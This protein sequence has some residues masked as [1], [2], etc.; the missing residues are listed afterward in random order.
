MSLQPSFIDTQYQFANYIRDPDNNPAPDNIEQ[1]RMTIYQELFYN[2][3]EGFA[4]NGFPVLREITTDE[5]WHKMIRDFM[6]KHRCKTPLFHEISR[7][8][9][10]YL[11]NERDNKNDPKFMKELAHYEW[12]E[13]ALSV[14]DAD[15]KP[16]QLNEG[17]DS[18]SFNLTLSPLAWSLAY[19]YPVHHI[20]PDFKPDKPSD[21]PHYLLVYRN[22]E[23]S[24]TFLE[25]NPVSARLIELLNEGM[26]GQ[27]AA[28]QIAQEL[29][30][31]NP[32][33]VIEG[34]RGLITD[35]IQREILVYARDK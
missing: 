12:V 16:V 22:R 17:Q 2:N 1:R 25:L 4:A 27:T 33:V 31:P 6:V 30:H 24:V 19:H 29:Q 28:E 14:L 8:F 35:W 34:A 23:D 10:A 18:L 32:H 7:E 26:N 21:S 3:I 9:L 20:G 11:E 13:L 5:A 15:V